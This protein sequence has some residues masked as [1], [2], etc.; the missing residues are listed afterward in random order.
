VDNPQPETL[1]MTRPLGTCALLTSLLLMALPG[2]AHYPRTWS[3][4]GIEMNAY[5]EGEYKQ[6][7]EG[8]VVERFEINTFPPDL[9]LNIQ[10]CSGP[11]ALATESDGKPKMESAGIVGSNYGEMFFRVAITN[12]TEHVVRLNQAVLRLHDPAG[13]AYEPM[14]RDEIVGLLESARPCP[15]TSQL[16]GKAKLVKLLDRNVEIVP[17]TT[18]TGYLV[19]NVSEEATQ[20]M[21]VWKLALYDLPVELDAAGKV[22]KAAAFEIRSVRRKLNYTYEQAKAGAEWTLVSSVPVEE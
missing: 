11:G 21:G 4:V 17:R 8:L 12:N 15:T 6:E 1:A 2:C 7:K 22:S 20:V 13:N 14:N 5:E 3:K 16:V 18:F 10:A 19:F 9:S